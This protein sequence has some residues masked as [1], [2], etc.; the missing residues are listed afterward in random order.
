L[1]A[2]SARRTSRGDM[3]GGATEGIRAATEIIAAL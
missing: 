1:P 3:E 2:S